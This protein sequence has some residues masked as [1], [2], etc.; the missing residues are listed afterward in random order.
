MAVSVAQPFA[1]T[2]ELALRLSE[3]ME[4]WLREQVEAT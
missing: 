1:P 2:V 3:V 4:Q